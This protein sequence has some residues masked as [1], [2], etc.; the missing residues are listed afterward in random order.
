MLDKIPRSG[1]SIQF[2]VHVQIYD[3]RFNNISAVS[4]RRPIPFPFGK[5]LKLWPQRDREI[6][7]LRL[8]ELVGVHW[9]V[10]E[11]W[12][13]FVEEIGPTLVDIVVAQSRETFRVSE[14]GHVLKS[15]NA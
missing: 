14:G 15:W 3:L 8:E 11:A 5:A 13:Y 6:T 4:T 2:P 10:H 9:A 1:R 12:N 7:H